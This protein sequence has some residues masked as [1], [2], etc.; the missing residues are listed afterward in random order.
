MNDTLKN[1]TCDRADDLISFLY[2]EADKSEARDFKQHLQACSN[3]QREYASF[4]EVRE[5]IAQWKT[6]AFSEPP[7]EM[8]PSATA[9]RQRS[10][11]AALR[12]FFA[13]SPLWLKGAVSFAAVVFCVIVIMSLNRTTPAPPTIT[14]DNGA[15]YTQEQVNEAVAKALADQANKLA[16]TTASKNQTAE[17]RSSEAIKSRQVPPTNRS[18]QWASSKPLSKAERKQLAADL[19]LLSG[20]DEDTLNLLSDRIN[21]EF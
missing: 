3:C 11:V 12:E 5:S 8:V 20:R 4:A 7:I 18:S 19:R 9:T 15:R 10:A 14:S 13:L 2:G 6:E 17:R 21:Q 1:L 16:S